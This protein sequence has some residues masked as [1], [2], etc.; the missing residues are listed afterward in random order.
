[1]SDDLFIDVYDSIHD[2][3]LNSYNVIVNKM[4]PYEIMDNSTSEVV[5]AHHIDDVLTAEEVANMIKW[6]EQDNEDYEKCA[7]LKHIENEIKRLSRRN[8]TEGIKDTKKE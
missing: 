2:A 3:M 7:K 8:Q 4:D 1:M 5:F 6:W